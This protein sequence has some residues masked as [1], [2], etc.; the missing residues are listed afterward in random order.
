ML[1]NERTQVRLWLEKPS[2]VA[3]VI[4]GHGA[5]EFARMVVAE[6]EE[7]A[8]LQG[9]FVI[10]N[11]TQRMPGYDPGFRSILTEW[12]ASKRERLTAIHILTASR[13]VAMGAAVANMMLGGNVKMYSDRRSFEEQ[14]ASAGGAPKQFMSVA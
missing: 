11:D 2:L 13:M 9:D 5:I 3:W 6:L 8:P 7:L 10:F 4:A 12:S 1:S 14:F